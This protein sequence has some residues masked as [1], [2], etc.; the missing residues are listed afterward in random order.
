MKIFTQKLLAIAVITAALPATGWAQQDSVII[1]QSNTTIGP[2][3]GDREFTLSGTGTSDKDF[4][5]SSMGVS[6]DLGWYLS[7]HSVWGIRQ[8]LNYADIEG[9]NTSDD[10]WNGS[11]RG[12]YDY[13]FLSGKARPFVGGSL[14]G[15]YGDGVND[16][17]FA[18]LEFGLKYYA[19]ENTFILA[20]AE[21]Q[22]FFDSGSDADD[23]FDDG[24]FS[25]VLGIGYHF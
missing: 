10:F 7:S 11:T 22:F 20:R 5:N 15:I 23:A 12:Y 8:S 21:Y 14:G 2:S 13:H 3:A 24:A 25:Y 16:S 6:A 17:F 4:D 18:G 9:E 19:L 1:A